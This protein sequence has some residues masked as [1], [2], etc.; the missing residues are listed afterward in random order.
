MRSLNQAPQQLF[1]SSVR[2]KRLGMKKS[3]ISKAD[4]DIPELSWY[5][6]VPLSP[7]LLCADGIFHFQLRAPPTRTFTDWVP[8]F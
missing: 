7:S 5:A 3:S 4:Q 6:A 2:E 8:A 1:E